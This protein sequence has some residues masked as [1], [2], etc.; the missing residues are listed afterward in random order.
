MTV[1]R[2]EVITGLA[3]VA[4]AGFACCTLPGRA[5]PPLV[6]V[7]R[8]FAKDDPEAIRYFL[9]SHDPAW[10]T[11]WHCHVH[12]FAQRT[13]RHR[14]SGLTFATDPRNSGVVSDAV[15]LARPADAPI[16]PPYTPE[17]FMLGYAARRIRLFA[18]MAEWNRR[19]KEGREGAFFLHD[20]GDE[21]DTEDAPPLARVV[22]FADGIV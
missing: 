16:V 15:W 4:V 2:R 6:C 11:G 13:L 12:N 20:Y 5:A 19:N 8:P 17:L 22:A 3:A 10:N 21:W 1:D 7:G 9:E 18:G 14:A